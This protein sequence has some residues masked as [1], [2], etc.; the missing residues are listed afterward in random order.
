MLTLRRISAALAAVLLLFSTQADI[1]AS[2]HCAHHAA[3]T[4]VPAASGHGHH[5]APDAPAEPADHAVCTCLGMCATTVITGVPSARIAASLVQTV[6]PIDHAR[7]A[8]DVRPVAV[9]HL[10]PFATAPPAVS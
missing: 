1:Y 9:R 8:D 2:S 4:A 10:I 5:G 7:P 3:A 6:H